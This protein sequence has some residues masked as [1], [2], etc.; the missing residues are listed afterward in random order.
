MVD[1]GGCGMASSMDP[2]SRRAVLASGTVA[3][4]AGCL[5]RTRSAVSAVW[6][7]SDSGSPTAVESVTASAD[8][9][10]TAGID[11]DAGFASLVGDQGS[12]E[13]DH[14]FSI[15]D[16]Q[17]WPTTVV[18][19][20]TGAIVAG[21]SG[22][23]PSRFVRRLDTTGDHVD[24]YR[25]GSGVVLGGASTG[26]GAVL[27]G[28]TGTVG[29]SPAWLMWL[30]GDGEVIRE[31]DVS[32]RD[33]WFESST[34]SDGRLACVGGADGRPWITRIDETG[35][36]AWE[37]RLTSLERRAVAMD[38]AWQGAAL[39]VVGAIGDTVGG[40]D[41]PAGGEGGSDGYVA[42]YDETGSL[43]D[44][45]VLDGRPCYGV[46][47]S[48]GV[49]V[50]GGAD[51]GQGWLGTATET[52]ATT[53]EGTVASVTAHGEEV[54]AGGHHLQE[55]H[56]VSLVE[57]ID[58]PDE[59]TP[60]DEEPVETEEP[61]VEFLDCQTVR[62]TG[63]F[64]EVQLHYH[65]WED[66]DSDS[67]G[68]EVAVPVGPVEGERVI[69]VESATDLSVEY[70]PVL[71]EVEAFAD[72][73]GV[74]G[75]GELLASNPEA[76]ACDEAITAQ[77][78][79]DEEPRIE[80]LDCQSARITGDFETVLVHYHWW[81]GD[82]PVLGNEVG[83][84][85]GGVD[86]ERTVSV[87]DATDATFEYGPV[88][89]GVDAFGEGAPQTPLGGDLSA[90]NPRVESCDERLGPPAQDAAQPD[91]TPPAEES[92]PEPETP[93]DQQDPDNVTPDPEPAPENDSVV[94]EPPDLPD[95]PEPSTEPQ[96]GDDTDAPA[97][98]SGADES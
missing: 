81:V 74:M 67:L 75:Q 98:V 68:N 53:G 36:L 22:D 6:D 45:E 40:R 11:G 27:T 42:T 80:F 29:E 93:P 30:D 4:V 96:G 15:D 10:L 72:P 59:H 52:L 1:T 85:V 76:S 79:E 37:D 5:E 34:W 16:D 87:A 92:A 90:S 54:V 55:G 50:L 64:A 88:L 62:V 71:T 84:P 69:S 28:A 21:W 19:I 31:R 70:G 41:R 9:I 7:R 82:P 33:P 18:S 49:V 39:V 48:A 56:S 43:Q 57:S 24:E 38:A 91:G 14:R 78:P 95:E 25:P 20:E 61:G 26:G 66:A 83:V 17:T 32:A 65:W 47:T 58:A 13:W 63:E 44:L 77:F 12:L 23:E 3:A 94:E 8:G 51:G 35:M 2:R 73:M 86:G 60:A 46:T 89:T 97:N